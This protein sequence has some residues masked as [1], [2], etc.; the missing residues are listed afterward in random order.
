MMLDSDWR[1]LK[2]ADEY[3]V[4]RDGRIRRV[5][6]SRGRFLGRELKAG[7]NA[8]YPMVT[9]CKDGKSY[10]RKVANLVCEA[11]HGPK[12]SPKHQVAH[13]NGNKADSTASNLRWATAKDNIADKEIHGTKT[14]GEKHWNAV[15]T[16]SQVLEIRR[17]CR[18]RRN[19]AEDYGVSV[20]TITDVQQRKSW[21]H[22]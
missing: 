3:A 22:I 4:S 6:A 15:L 16:E 7:L 5:K 1:L 21:R 11:F 18:I 2:F 20:H 10:S 13:N 19:I 14:D 17:D 8:G 12:P 9:I